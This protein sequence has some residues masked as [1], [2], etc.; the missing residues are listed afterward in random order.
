MAAVGRRVDEPVVAVAADEAWDALPPEDRERLAA[1]EVLVDEIRT[2]EAGGAA[3]MS[4]SRLWLSRI[5]N[6]TFAICLGMPLK[7]TSSGYRLYRLKAML[8]K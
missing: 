3:E 8:A 1:G 5:L 6:K 4:A 7:D 2:D